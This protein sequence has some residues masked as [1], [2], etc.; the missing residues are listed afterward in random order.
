MSPSTSFNA[1]FGT[2]DSWK[3]F[4]TSHPMIEVSSAGFAITL[5]PVT[6]A[7]VICPTNI[8]KGK[9]HGLIQRNVPL[10]ACSR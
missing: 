2:P 9:F 5:F 7:A 3:I 10:G 8:A 6:S 1:D 4:T